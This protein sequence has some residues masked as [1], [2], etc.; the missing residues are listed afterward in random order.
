MYRDA[1]YCKAEYKKDYKG[2]AVA[3]GVWEVLSVRVLRQRVLEIGASDTVSAVRRLLRGSQK[4]KF[5]EMAREYRE[6]VEAMW[7]QYPSWVQ[8]RLRGLLANLYI[9]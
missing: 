8:G 1:I 5:V 7:S 2:L 3:A 6:R 4:A 9:V